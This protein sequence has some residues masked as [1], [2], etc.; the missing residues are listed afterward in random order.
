MIYLTRP[1]DNPSKITQTLLGYND[2]SYTR[3]LRLPYST[4][5]IKPYYPLVLPE[6]NHDAIQRNCA[7]QIARLPSQQR[8]MIQ[9]LQQSHIDPGYL[10]SFYNLLKTTFTP[11]NGHNLALGFG[12]AQFLERIAHQHHHH[13]HRFHHLMDDTFHTLRNIAT[14]TT[15]T[16][17]EELYGHY[18][19]L[20]NELA[21]DFPR[22]FNHYIGRFQHLFHENGYHS[23]RLHKKIGWHFTHELVAHDLIQMIDFVKQIGQGLF[24]LDITGTLIE[25]GLVISHDNHWFQ[26]LSRMV[27]DLEVFFASCAMIDTLFALLC[28]GPIGWIGIIAATTVTLLSQHELMDHVF[29]PY[30]NYIDQTYP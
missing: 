5:L 6:Y 14:S 2:E 17:R 12:A 4:S 28:A 15:H 19:K 16:A 21:H 24:V 30:L 7:S 18:K 1:G 13:L 3:L 8:Y 10:L 23:I 26:Q 20:R 25:A 9:Q 11:N 29:T 27:V 22:E